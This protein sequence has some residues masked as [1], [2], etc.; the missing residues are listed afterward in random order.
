MEVREGALMT[1]RYQT[2]DTNCFVL[3]TLTFSSK[4]HL[5]FKVFDGQRLLTTEAVHSFPNETW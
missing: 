5:L 3:L 4:C 2:V 1:K